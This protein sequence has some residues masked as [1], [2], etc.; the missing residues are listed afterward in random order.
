MTMT[1]SPAGPNLM[2]AADTYAS[3]HP[4]EDGLVERIDGRKLPTGRI[5]LNVGEGL[6]YTEQMA[7]EYQVRVDYGLWRAA[8]A[9]RPEGTLFIEDPKLKMPGHHLV[10]V[11]ARYVGD[12]RSLDPTPAQIEV[13]VDPFAPQLRAELGEESV[14]VN[15]IDLDTRYIDK[16]E[17]E[18]RIDEGAWFDVAVMPWSEGLGRAELPYSGLEGA[19]VLTL[20]ATD[21]AGNESEIATIR[22]G[23][24]EIEDE[25]PA[26]GC[27][28][29]DAGVPHGHGEGVLAAIAALAALLLLRRR[30]N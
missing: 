12:Y 26:K 24:T 4:T 16:L 14:I 3:V 11:R 27:A 29:H 23:L 28:C 25:R 2:L 21:P 6:P 20:R 1:S 9:P 8:R 30:R 17:L 19:D 7:L 15:V 13:V 22:L 18:A 10:E 5:R